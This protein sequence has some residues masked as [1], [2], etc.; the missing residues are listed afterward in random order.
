[1]CLMVMLLGRGETGSC[2]ARARPRRAPR[3]GPPGRWTP[4]TG[5]GPCRPS[6][7]VGRSFVHS[8]ALNVESR[9]N[10]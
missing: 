5:R 10:Y 9:Q 4:W 8:P 6:G 7:R 2:G 3:G 1:M